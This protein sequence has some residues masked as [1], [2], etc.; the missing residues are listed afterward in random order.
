[1]K[2]HPT[3]SAPDYAKVWD[4]A[5]DQIKEVSNWFML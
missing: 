2:L 4:A 1:M 3:T 5:D